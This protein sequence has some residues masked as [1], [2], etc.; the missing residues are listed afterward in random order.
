MRALEC[1][2]TEK[3][4]YSRA[5]QMEPKRKTFYTIIYFSWHPLH[6]KTFVRVKILYASIVK[7]RIRC[8]SLKWCGFA[9]FTILYSQFAMEYV[10][11]SW[12]PLWPYLI[13]KIETRFANA[14]QREKLP[15]FF[16]TFFY[17]IVYVLLG[18]VHCVSNICISSISAFVLVVSWVDHS[19]ERYFNCNN[20][21]NCK[22]N[23][24]GQSV[25]QSKF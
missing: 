17:I 21:N 13:N 4:N 16:N 8:Y 18:K 20:N 6:C 3:Q 24:N 2:W 5:L 23:K 15:Q 19:F 10:K 25:S 7:S 12:S 14:N 11:K 22:Q 9:S 1:D